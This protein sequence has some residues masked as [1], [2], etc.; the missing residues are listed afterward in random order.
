MNRSL[1]Q[2]LPH[3]LVSTVAPRDFGSEAVDAHAQTPRTF[4]DRFGAFLGFLCAIHCLAVPLL[5]GVLPAVGL[6][7]LAAHEFD[8]AIIGFAIVF[9]GLA[10]RSGYRAHGDKRLVYGFGAAV[11]LLIAGHLLGE[12][13]IAGRIPSIIGG[14][15]LAALHFVNLRK[16]RRS[17]AC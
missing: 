14:F 5:L 16:T 6:G 10:A 3:A 13:G 15:S 8:L 12:G 7:F 17:C 4:Y 11:A 1:P 2:P 9:A